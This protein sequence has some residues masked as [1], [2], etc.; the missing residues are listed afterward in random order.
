MR[1]ITIRNV[2]PITEA[3]IELKRINIVIGPQSQGKSTLLKV[4]CFC[5]W[6]EKRIEL[7]Q[8]DEYFLSEDGFANHLWAFHK[9]EEYL[10][11]DSYIAYESDYMAFSYCH[12]SRKF[13]FKW[14]NGRW[15]YRRS[16][17][18]Y[19][20]SERNI[21]A[22]IPNWFEVTLPLNNIR[23]FMADWETARRAST[24]SSDVLNLGVSYR[25]DPQSRQDKIQITPGKSLNFTN[26]SSGLQ[27]LV[28]MFVVLDYLYTYIYK[29][30]TGKRI[31]DVAEN[32][33]LLRLIYEELFQKQNRTKW[34]QQSDH[35]VFSDRD[36]MVQLPYQRSIDGI[37]LYFDDRKTADEC[38]EIYSRYV[39]TDHCDVFL[40][41]PESNLFP[42]TQREVA[43]WLIENTLSEREHTLSI[44]THSPYMLG[45]FLEK[46]IEVGL[47][48]CLKG[49]T[50]ITIHTATE[51]ELQAIYS[52]GIDAFF[53]LENIPS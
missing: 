22:A 20:P 28:P 5:V 15:K 34:R 12:Q 32:E 14:K 26:T 44:T 29:V 7:A 45:A 11:P 47:F 13:S 19:L 39:K 37:R 8:T 16:K 36:L 3:D 10:L 51:A 1:K 6:V 18:S 24:K 42:P 27:S 52:D 21:V 48:Y 17:I 41:E 38:E 30:E 2:G 50:S 4:A 9:L 25:F 33:Q 35:D 46:N 53:N 49:E 40:E 31:T 43:H 23:N